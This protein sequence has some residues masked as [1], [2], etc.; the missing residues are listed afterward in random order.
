M[1]GGRVD[2]GGALLEGRNDVPYTSHSPKIHFVARMR[3]VSFLYNA[4]TSAKEN[5][6]TLHR[7]RTMRPLRWASPFTRIKYCAMSIIL[8]LAFLATSNAFN[9]PTTNSNVHASELG[10]S[11]QTVSRGG[12]IIHKTTRRPRQILRSAP[13]R[14]TDSYDLD[15]IEEETIRGQS[16]RP[17]AKSLRRNRKGRRKERRKNVGRTLPTEPA[18]ARNGS[19]SRKKNGRGR[20]PSRTSRPESSGEPM[21]PWLARYENK[22]FSGTL[23]RL[24]ETSQQSATTTSGA[25]DENEKEQ[26]AI[27]WM[28][29]LQMAL[30][31]IFYRATDDDAPL[32]TMPDAA[33]ATSVASTTIP[34]TIPYFASLEVNEILDSVRVASHSNPN[35]MSGCADF[36]YLM[37]TLE[38][39]GVLT[40]DYLSDEHWDD[41]DIS[42]VEDAMWQNEED[43]EARTRSE[44]PHSIMTRDVLVAAAFHYCDCVR[45]RK[46][47]VY[48]YA[49]RAMEA[50]SDGMMRKDLESRKQLG[51]A[52]DLEM[53]RSNVDNGNDATKKLDDKSSKSMEVGKLQMVAR[54]GETPIKHYGKESVR[55]ATGA[56]RLKR[57]EIMATTVYCTA[58]GGG[59]RRQNSSRDDTAQPS[60]NV[61]ILRSFLVSLL[62]DWRALVI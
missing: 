35:L 21:P 45:A 9:F 26:I 52:S 36:L 2:R 58:G 14:D 31:G 17:N 29:H 28:Q 49:R 38:E 19:S 4:E 24:P 37:L 20:R 8:V 46:A 23:C 27:T 48:D 62:E 3:R 6:H 56:A 47:G 61:E 40:S 1:R 42:G 15:A 13:V 41:G 43:G 22:D 7:R 32:T 54:R 12:G 30:S 60:G 18:A 5:I 53:E 11:L 16:P 51:L 25:D 57:A 10:F 33:A 55:I 44:E 59:G 34:E 50:S 39:E